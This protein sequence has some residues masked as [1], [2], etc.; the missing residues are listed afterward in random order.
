MATPPRSVGHTHRV[1]IVDDTLSDRR[2][3]ARALERAGYDV[4]TAEDGRSGLEMM[5]SGNY[6]VVIVDVNSSLA[7]F[8]LCPL[9]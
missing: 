1:L 6:S 9:R 4:D 3:A 8:A 2:L 7:L 5:S